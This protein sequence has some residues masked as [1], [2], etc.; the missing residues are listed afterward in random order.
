MKIRTKFLTC[1]FAL[2][3]LI[4]YANKKDFIG[5]PIGGINCGQVYIGE[6]GQL[7]YWDIFN[8]RKI[9]PGGPGDKFYLNPMQQSKEFEQGFAI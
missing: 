6:D 2:L 8:I 1:A 5:M 7:W 3:T 4:G 9:N